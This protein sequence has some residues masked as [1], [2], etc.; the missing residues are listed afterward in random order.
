MRRLRIALIAIVLVL[1]IAAAAQETEQAAQET[2]PEKRPFIEMF[3]PIYLTTGIP[4]T[5]KP[6][7]E[8]AD[9]KFQ[10][11]FGIPLWRDMRGS[12]IDLMVAYT[13][14]SLWNL[15]G[16]SS[17]FYDNMYIPGIYARKVW[18]DAE[19]RPKH[20][21]LWGLEHRSNGRNDGY[22]RSINYLLV[23]YARMFPSGLTLQAAGRL[24]YGWYGDVVTMD[25]GL[26]YYGFLQTSLT[27]M[28]PSRGWEFMVSATPLWN[29]SV[30]NVQAEIS[31]RIGRRHDNP[32]FFVQFH[33]G[34]D[35]AF[36]ECVDEYG[37]LLE[38]D[39]S[40]P[41]RKGTPA[42]PR[43]MLRFGIM[44]HPHSFMRGNI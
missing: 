9:V 6:T 44:L 36:R 29:R 33:Y 1:P 13:Q 41:Y 21:L 15:Y 31:R 39:G 4:V 7:A 16:R 17:P 26:K 37:P 25:I 11:G 35:E 14:I 8:N 10:V 28:T 18:N 5:Q 23:S 19:A 20:A 32:Y 30:A 42:A 3:R 22:S 34:Y 40:A 38:E 12:G 27:Y 2:V 24:G 43:A